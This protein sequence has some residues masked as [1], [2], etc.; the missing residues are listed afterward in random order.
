MGTRS[1]IAI[2]YADGTV[3]QVYCHW[4]GYL[5]HNGKILQ[6]HYSDPYKLRDLIDQGD[7][8]SLGK[9]IGKKHPFGPAYNETDAVK[10]A[11]IQKEVDEAREAGY[12]TFYKRDRGEEGV[13][14]RQFA[15][16]AD[17]FANHQYEEYE[18]ILRNVDGVATWF[19][20][21][22][23]DVYVFLEEAF[24]KEEVAA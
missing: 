15:N 1:T 4:D 3:E 22:H 16:I 10:K 6:E 11:K 17:Y 2:E 20:A 5:E 21:V 8:S 19:V 7:I 14:A 13:E 9:S 24:N 23:S 12:T 18:Y